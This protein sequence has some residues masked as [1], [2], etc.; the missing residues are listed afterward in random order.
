MKEEKYNNYI[1]SFKSLESDEKKEL[2]I[3]ELNEIINTFYK[4][5]LDFNKND[6]ILSMEEEFETEDEFLIKIFTQI[7]SLKEVSADTLSVILDNYYED[8]NN[9]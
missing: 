3:S 9:E 4:I 5:S 8:G 2:I 7:L 1:N 6:K